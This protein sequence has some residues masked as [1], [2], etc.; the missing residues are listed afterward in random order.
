MI[1]SINFIILDV[2][3]QT[4]RAYLIPRPRQPVF[5]SLLFAKV[6]S[7]LRLQGWLISQKHRPYSSSSNL[8]EEIKVNR[9]M[10]DKLLRDAPFLL[11][12]LEE[13]Q[14]DLQVSYIP[15]I[16]L[17]NLDRNFTSCCLL[18]SRHCILL[19][20]RDTTTVNVNQPTD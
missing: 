20:Y 14:F 18:K 9:G 6:A 17:F 1:P 10:T 11:C 13:R 8:V 16:L 4:G 12:C 2:A 5:A 19:F 3:S 15:C 7:G